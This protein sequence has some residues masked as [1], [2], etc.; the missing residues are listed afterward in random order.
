M[1][2]FFRLLLLLPL[3]GC[4]VN[5]NEEYINTIAPIVRQ[6]L[7]DTKAALA[8]GRVLNAQILKDYAN[9]LPL[10]QPTL[11]APAAVLAVEA[12]A[13]SQLLKHF[14]QRLKVAE[15][16]PNDLG[17]LKMAADEVRA[18]REATTTAVYND[19]LLDP[20]NTLADLSA[21]Q[22][23]RLS[24]P[25]PREKELPASQL[26][27]NPAYGEWKQNSQGSNF[28]MWYGAYRMLDDVVGGGR[29]YNAWQSG[30]SWSYHNDYG[31]RLYG[32]RADDKTM[33][34][35]RK[36][37]QP[38]AGIVPSERKRYGSSYSRRNSNF[39]AARNSFETPGYRADSI[40]NESAARPR[41][42]FSSSYGGSR[43]SRR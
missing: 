36:Q 11:A 21:G 3:T 13:N 1:H 15:D 33:R 31:R 17:G 12:T 23:P 9:R 43:R 26:V 6:Q 41:K 24:A 32:S 38:D 18:L 19:A 27:G 40:F 34:T 28:W 5:E 2:L 8:A 30:R 42:R 25:K 29:N 14:E 37:Y 10:M 7:A 39:S 35:M 22:L 16:S 20:I 4:L